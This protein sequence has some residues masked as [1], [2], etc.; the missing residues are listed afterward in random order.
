MSAGSDPQTDR[1]PDPAVAFFDLFDP[2]FQPD[3]PAVHAAREACWYARTSLGYAVLRYAEVAALLRDRRLRQGGVESLAA[4]GVT[5]GPLADW[6]RAVILNQEGE[7]HARLR[8][9]VSQA[10][11]PRAVDALRPTMRAVAHELIDGFA[12]ARRVRVHGGLRRP[13]P[14]A[15]HGRAARH[16]ARAVRPVPRLDHRPR[17]RLQLRRG[18]GPPPDR[19]GTPGPVRLRRRPAR[20]A[21]RRAGTRPALRAH[22]R[23][24]SRRPAERRGAAR[25]W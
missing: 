11:T 20:R 15:R 22:R 13:L 2:D 4:Q 18:P 21:A 16:P 14:L 23:R 19:G 7:Q 6:M 1:G 10:F 17:P 12:A 5:E 3:A 8:R 25:T 24:R 9:L